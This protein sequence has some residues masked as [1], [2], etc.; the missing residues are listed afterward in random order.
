MTKIQN[1]RNQLAPGGLFETHQRTPGNAVVAAARP[2]VVDAGQAATP[3]TAAVKPVG[4]IEDVLKPLP[5]VEIAAI[6]VV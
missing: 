1:P 4:I 6:G 5:H 2:V 3:A